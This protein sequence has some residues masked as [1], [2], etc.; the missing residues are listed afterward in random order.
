MK[1]LAIAVIGALALAGIGAGVSSAVDPDLT[2]TG[3]VSP[4][5]HGTK[6]KPKK[7]KL[8]V[9]LA[10]TPKAGEPAFAASDTIVH[11]GNE[12]VFNGKALKQC[13]SSVVLSDDTKCPKGSKVGKGVAAGTAL[14]L[15]EPLTVTAYNGTGGKKLELL[16]DGTSPLQIHA[17]IE[18]ILSKDVAP[19]GNKLSVHVPDN[20]QQPAPGAYATLT[21]FDTTINAVTGKKKAPYV[22]IASCKDKQI[23]LGVDYIYTDGTQKSAQTTVACK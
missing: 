22:G 14:G 7:T 19:Y 2:I 18:G 8:V 16:V 6:K 1:K 4:S 17:V 5:S 3:S 9:K 12:L 13:A 20:L 10:T 15:T 11:L 21:Q 23:S